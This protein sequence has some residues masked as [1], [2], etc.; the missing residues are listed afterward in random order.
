MNNELEEIIKEVRKAGDEY[1]DF[2]I[3]NSIVREDGVTELTTTL[4]NHEQYKE[5]SKKRTEALNKLSD[6]HKNKKS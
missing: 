4:E 5:L 3:Q 6:Y 1:D 2:I